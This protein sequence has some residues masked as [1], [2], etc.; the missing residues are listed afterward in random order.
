VGKDAPDG[1]FYTIFYYLCQTKIIAFKK[2]LVK[3]KDLKI[4]QLN[5]NT[6]PTKVATPFAAVPFHPKAKKVA[7]DAVHKKGS[8]GDEPL[9]LPQGSVR[10]IITLTTLIVF[11]IAVMISMF[12]D[13]QIP[14]TLTSVVITVIAFYFGTRVASKPT[15]EISVQE[16]R[17]NIDNIT[18]KDRSSLS[19]K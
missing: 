16:M 1:F 4:Y 14:E 19:K 8:H 15:E 5:K 12:L 17:G 18:T 9:G 10:A 11:L 3:L 7:N 13:K 6:M 2:N